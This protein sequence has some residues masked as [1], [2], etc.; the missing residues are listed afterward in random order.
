MA[1]TAEL[2]AGSAWPGSAACLRLPNK[3]P[4]H[5]QDPQHVAGEGGFSPGQ[6]KGQ[7]RG[8]SGL[9]KAES[10]PLQARSSLDLAVGMSPS[11]DL[12][13][14]PRI[15][16][17]P[18]MYKRLENQQLPVCSGR[19]RPARTEPALPCSPRP[20]PHPAPSPLG[21]R[22]GAASLARPHPSQEGPP[23]NPRAC[24]GFPSHRVGQTTPPPRSHP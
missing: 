4:A 1:E 10:P 23:P 12:R 17:T 9:R 15:P 16:E 3:V 8:S 7:L 13:E 24:A 21:R 18:T 5:P 22:E 20:T 14:R 6:L 19:S 11:A 2:G